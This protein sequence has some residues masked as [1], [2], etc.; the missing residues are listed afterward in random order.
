MIRVCVARDFLEFDRLCVEFG[1][2]ESF[3]LFISSDSPNDFTKMLGLEL[4]WDEVW[5]SD[6]CY[7]GKYFEDIWLLTQY[8]IVR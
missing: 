2:L 8:R 3:V 1:W 6:L 7:D 5:W 4:G